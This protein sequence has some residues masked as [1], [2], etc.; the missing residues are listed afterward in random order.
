[1]ANARSA[2]RR[3]RCSAGRCQNATH[4]PRPPSTLPLGSQVILACEAGGTLEPSVNFPLGKESRSL[5]GAWRLVES[6][7]LPAGQVK[8]LGGGVFRWAAA[9]LPMVGEYDGSGAGRTPGA[10][11][12]PT[13]AFVDGKK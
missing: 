8:H 9:G 13:G 2:D 7:A 12:A 3:G 5:K 4:P 10:A 11:E 6:Q 1:M